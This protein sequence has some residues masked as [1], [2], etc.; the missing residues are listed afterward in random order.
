MKAPIL[1]AVVALYAASVATA[2][3]WRIRIAIFNASL[4]RAAAGQLAADL[5]TTENLQA[6]QVAEIIQRVRP[7]VI[8]INEFDH[9]AQGTSLQRFHDNYL[10]IAQ[11]GEAPL[12]YP[13][14]YGPLSNTGVA[15]GFDLDNNGFANTT[16]PPL[17]AS[18][19]TKGNYGNDC[20]GFGWFPG[21]YA[22]VVYSRFPI[23]AAAIRNFQ[24][25]LW[26]DMPGAVLPDNLATTAVPD[27][28]YSP[29]EL[30]VLRLSSKNH[31]DIPIEIAPGEVLH[32]LASH[33]TPPA[34][35]GAEDRNGRRNHDEIRFW[36]D[37][38]SSAG[39]LYDDGGVQGGL[40]PDTR[41][42]V[43][44]DLNADPLDGDS[45]A[46]AVDQLRTHPLIDASFNP[47]S[48][49]GTQQA[50]LQ[51]G[52][53]RNHRGDPAFD[54][55]DFNDFSVGN[56]RVDHLLASKAG[57]QPIAGAVFWPLNTE[58]TFPL[59]SASDHRL[60]YTDYAMVPAISRAV[61][62]LTATQESRNV[63]LRWGSQRGVTYRVQSSVDLKAWDEAPQIVVTDDQTDQRA[64]ALDVE[65]TSAA[66]KFYRVVAMF[67]GALP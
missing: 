62:D 55:S 2:E 22:F 7:D 36:A 44:G 16:T 35:D 33:P 21:Q 6:R 47:A 67:E 49:G 64:S 43:L 45:Y 19:T 39:Y 11:N 66:K 17:N 50:Q 25:F 46:A 56:L 23:N 5:S 61:R 30:A 48:P 58:A 18:N 42:V 3:P 51:G 31:C 34:F 8:L 60:V 54:T 13:H 29:A 14:R 57:L 59:V 9:D 24:N 20:F 40:A 4:N 12:N 63:L 26:R 27:D 32:L 1:A 52:T 41:F 15:S 53:N 37:Y 28:W 10:A 38:V 65:I